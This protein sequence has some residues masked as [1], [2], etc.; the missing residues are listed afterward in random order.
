V[1][2][3]GKADGKEVV[4]HGVTKA[5]ATNSKCDSTLLSLEARQFATVFG[6]EGMLS[7]SLGQLIA[8]GKVEPIVKLVSGGEVQYWE[9]LDFDIVYKPQNKKGKYRVKV[10]PGGQGWVQVDL[11]RWQ[12]VVQA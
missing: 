12:S 2:V 3:I 11:A 6:L 4:C 9:L 5:T 10:R 1:V 7:T 8:R